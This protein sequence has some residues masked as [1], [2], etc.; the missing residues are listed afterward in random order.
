MQFFKKFDAL[1]TGIELWLDSNQTRDSVNDLETIEKQV[2]EFEKTFSRFLEESELSQLNKTDGQFKASSEMMV[3]LKLAKDFYK[4]TDGLFDPTV[5]RPLEKLGYNKSFH[6][7]GELS[8]EKESSEPDDLRNDVDFEKVVIDD[9]NSTVSIPSN[10]KIDLGGIGK[11]Y[12][13]DILAKQLVEWGYENF[14]I[15]AGGDMFLSGQ[16]DGKS[17]Q[18]GV[19]NPLKHDE[20]L[21]DIEV[22]DNHLAVATSGTTKRHWS[23]E[24][25]IWH[26]II[27]P[28]TGLSAENDLLAV[29]VVCTNIIEADVF[30]KVAFV[31]GKE[32]GLDFINKQKNVEGLIIDKDLNVILSREMSDYLIQND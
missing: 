15:S 23:K 30:A 6:T 5:A 16:K 7:L 4:R 24:G 28:Q 3:L 10:I 1:G 32:K 26:H 9:Q 25:K 27:D 20:D 22:R 29:T 14:W 21:L 17:H 18:V 19:Q 13:V 8:S 12:I 11:G 31:L 2:V